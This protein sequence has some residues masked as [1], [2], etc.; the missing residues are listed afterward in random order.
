MACAIGVRFFQIPRTTHTPRAEIKWVMEHHEN[1]TDDEKLSAF[2][3]ALA[4][5]CGLVPIEHPAR[6]DPPL[7]GA[8]TPRRR[9]H[10]R[11][12]RHLPQRPLWW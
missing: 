11:R 1:M 10:N 9:H 8:L 6:D 5:Q 7:S 2:L 4:E 3:W 12:H